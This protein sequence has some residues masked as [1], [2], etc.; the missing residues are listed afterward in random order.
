MAVSLPNESIPNIPHFIPTDKNSKR[1]DGVSIAALFA[2][3]PHLGE[4]TLFGISGNKIVIQEPCSNVPFIGAVKTQGLYRKF[5]GDSRSDLRDMCIALQRS[6]EWYK[7]N[8]D[9]IELLNDTIPGIQVYKKKKQYERDAILDT[10]QTTID[11]IDKVIKIYKLKGKDEN[12]EIPEVIWISKPIKNLT[13]QEE[14]TFKAWPD[15]E[16]KKI[17][18]NIKPITKSGLSAARSF[19]ESKQE[20]LVPLLQEEE[21]YLK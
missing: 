3:Y 6:V 12:Q 2:I 16:I 15:E 11:T 13:K 7:N 5:Y 18:A 10:L 9:F 4:G 17:L 8:S 1:L 21:K 19:I 20:E 14:H